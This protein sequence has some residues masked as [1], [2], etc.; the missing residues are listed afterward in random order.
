MVMPS[1]LFEELGFN[2]LGPIDGHD[3]PV[4]MRTIQT[5]KDVAGPNLLHIITAKGKGY[6]PAEKDPV[7]YHAV[8]P[9]D[10][11]KGVE[12]K[13]SPKVQQPSYTQVFGQWLC[14]M[15]S[16]DSRIV[17]ITPAMREGSGLVQFEKQFPDRYF[18]V[19]IAEQHSVT[20]A[21]GLAC[22][23]LKPVVAIYST[24]LQ[25]GFEACA[26][27]SF[28]P[29]R[30]ARDQG[31]AEHDEL[32]ALRRRV[33]NPPGDLVQRS[34]AVQPDRGDLGEAHRQHAFRFILQNQ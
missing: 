19:G 10:P 11:E 30:V 3:L 20:L 4:L 25:R 17:G 13:P 27:G 18:D 7:K 23:G 29:E 22:E 34:V 16:K 9:F 1:T 21:A 14:D 24:F 33:M 28:N 31:F 8:G 2:Y 6:A 5:A 12:S 32:A 15:A 26:I